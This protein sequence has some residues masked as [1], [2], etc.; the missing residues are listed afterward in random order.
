MS[1]QPKKTVVVPVDFSDSTQGALEAA[2]DCAFR[3][4]NIH[5]V[6][7]VWTPD[8]APPFGT[9]NADDLAIRRQNARNKINELLE[10]NDM[11]GAEIC[12]LSGEPGQRI[13]EY[14]EQVD[15]DLVV[16]PS[17]GYSGFKRM[18]LGSTAERVIRHTSCPVYVLRRHDAK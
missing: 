8:P 11:L 12:V 4:E 17:H 7:V 2:K 10:A 6:H 16:I 3:N 18:L 5:V 13:V 1:W 14:T 9:W 15:A